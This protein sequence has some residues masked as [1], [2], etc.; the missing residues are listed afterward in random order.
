MQNTAKF[1]ADIASND[2]DVRFAAWRSAGSM[3]PSVIP[4]LG[5]LLTSS[6]PGIAKAAGEALTTMTHS[7]GKDPAD[8]RRRGV[9]QGLLG[10]TSQPLAFRLLSLV[11]AESDTP[12]I[13][14]HL[15]DPK[16]REE[17]IFCL[18]RMPGTAPLQAIVAAYSSAPDDFKPRLLAALG[19]RRAPQGVPLCVEAMKSSNA[20]IAAAGARALGRIGAA[21]ASPIAWPAAA[22]DAQLRYAEHRPGEALGIYRGLLARPEEHIQCAALAGLG[23]IGSPQAAA[24]IHPHLN[25]QVRNVRLTARQAWQSIAAAPSSVT[26]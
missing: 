22:F 25:S 20:E 3:P 4:E 18:E 24:L 13:A 11:A 16:A 12:A 10:L 1:M 6:N 19:H 14:R 9:I 8:P 21:P 2:A 15:S 7:V 5:R 23:R 17:A 26:K